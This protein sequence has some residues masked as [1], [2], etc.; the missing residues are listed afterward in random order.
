M[1]DV[2]PRRKHIFLT[3][4]KQVGKSTLLN[5]LI[6]RCGI[7]HSGFRTQPLMMNGERKG[8]MLHGYVPLPV[9]EQDAVISVRLAQRMTVPVPEAF[10]AN[11]VSI[12]SA[13]R[14]S[15]APF[16]LMDELGRLESGVP[17]FCQAVLD[18]L[19]GDK[20]VIGV[21]QQCDAPLVSAVAARSDVLVVTVT[22]DNRDALVDRLSPLL[23]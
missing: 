11:G 2:F 21:L 13:S 5:K 16:I 9:W 4:E 22:P 8:F 7:V 3:G 19:D 23:K 15:N 17:E 10:R 18:T 12:L 20:R 6:D 1:C 14:E